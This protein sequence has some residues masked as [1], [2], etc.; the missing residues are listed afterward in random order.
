MSAD[1]KL[2]HI[3]TAVDSSMEIRVSASYHT[4]FSWGGGADI[5][6]EEGKQLYDLMQNAHKCGR[7]ARLWATPEK[8]DVWKTLLDAGQD[9]ISVDDMVR[10]RKFYLEYMAG[11]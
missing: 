5:P 4:F 7:Q 9:W 11:K 2:N 8:E 1:G 10:F 6:L 3:N